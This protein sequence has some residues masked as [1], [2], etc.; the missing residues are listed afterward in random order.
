MCVGNTRSVQNLAERYI[1]TLKDFFSYTVHVFYNNAFLCVYDFS[2]HTN[3]GTNERSIGK[4][5]TGDSY[6]ASFGTDHGLS[7]THIF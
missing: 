6:V 1:E 7:L 4:S 2:Q 5:H 3:Q